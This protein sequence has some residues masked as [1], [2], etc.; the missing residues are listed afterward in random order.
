MTEQSIPAV[1]NTKDNFSLEVSKFLLESTKK[2]LQTIPQLINMGETSWEVL[3]IF[4][5]LSKIK[6]LI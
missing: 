4:L 3:M 5:L 1:W 6:T 2:Q